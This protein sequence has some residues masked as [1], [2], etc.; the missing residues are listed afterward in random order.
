MGLKAIGL[1]ASED[2][3]RRLAYAQAQTIDWNDLVS[4]EEVANQPITRNG[5]PPRG[6]VRH[7]ELGATTGLAEPDDENLPMIARTLG[8]YRDLSAPPRNLADSVGGLGKMRALQPLGGAARP[9]LEGRMIRISGFMTPLNLERGR[10][11]TFLLTPY[12]G[13][14][15]HVPPPPANQIIHVSDLGDFRADQGLLF[16]IRVS[17]ELIVGALETDLAR[18]GYAIAGGLIERLN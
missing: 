2:D 1:S 17:G 12:T 5:E 8:A 11:T 16:P 18:V 6:L 13:A 15:I 3:L 10:I 7:G 4:S 14:C 9:E